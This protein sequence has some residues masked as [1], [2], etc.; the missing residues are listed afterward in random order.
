MKCPLPNCP[1]KRQG[2]PKGSRNKKIRPRT[3]RPRSSKPL[4][5]AIRIRRQQLGMSQYDLSIAL[6]ARTAGSHTHLQPS[7]ISEIERGVRRI[8]NPLLQDIATVLQCSVSYLTDV[9]PAQDALIAPREIFVHLS[10]P[11]AHKPMSSA[12]YALVCKHFGSIPGFV[13]EM[14]AY[15][16]VSAN[17]H[18]TGAS[19]ICQ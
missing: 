11:P 7:R 16:G 14:I 3:D 12:V 19:A 15:Y 6:C 2:R 5:E 18:F 10:T 8:Q 13:D 17:A 1:K 4:G 9:Q